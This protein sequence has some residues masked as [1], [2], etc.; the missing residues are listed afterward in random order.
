MQ[1]HI[2]EDMRPRRRAKLSKDHNLSYTF[3]VEAQGI[4]YEPNPYVKRLSDH[5]IKLNKKT[6]NA[7]GLLDLKK[8]GLFEMN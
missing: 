4:A 8:L 7:K 2:K 1:K 5:H 6:F 3:Y